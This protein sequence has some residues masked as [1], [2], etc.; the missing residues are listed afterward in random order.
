[1]QTATPKFPPSWSSQTPFSME[2]TSH[3]LAAA[4]ISAPEQPEEQQG[5]R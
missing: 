5:L 1:M 3:A 4:P 2:N